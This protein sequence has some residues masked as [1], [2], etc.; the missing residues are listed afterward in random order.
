MS[1]E[2][3][4]Q[5]VPQQTGSYAG[6][7]LIGGALVGGAGG[8]GAV[9]YKNWGI[10]KDKPDLDKVFSQEPDS[11]TSQIERAEGDN[12]TFLEKAKEQAETVIK[13]AGEDFDAEEKKIKEANPNI[14]EAELKAKLEAAGLK[15]TREECINEAKTKAKEAVKE[16]AEKAKFASKT[17]TGVLAAA[18]VGLIGLGIGASIKKN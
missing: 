10:M 6:A 15:G 5:Q 4:T 9:H 14:A 8:Y 16:Y 18:V 2:L 12:K 7:G 3:L 11:F 13:K 17:W 1:D